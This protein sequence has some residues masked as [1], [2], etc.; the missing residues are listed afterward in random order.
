MSESSIQHYI[1]PF[2][3]GPPSACCGVLG[4]GLWYD[5]VI[6]WTLNQRSHVF[7]HQH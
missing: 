7:E 6:I 3:Y 2:K 1:W 5:F 4:I